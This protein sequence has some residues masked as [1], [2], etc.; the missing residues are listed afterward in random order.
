M[1][2]R[3]EHLEEQDTDMQVRSLVVGQR[4]LRYSP[5]Y[6]LYVPGTMHGRVICCG[7]QTALCGMSAGVRVLYSLCVCLCVC[8]CVCLCLCLSFFVCRDLWR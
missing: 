4:T 2:A 6:G 7:Y 5:V 3:I 1:Q 8:V